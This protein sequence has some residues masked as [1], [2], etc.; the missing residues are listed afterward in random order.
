MK[1]WMHKLFEDKS[2]EG[3]RFRAGV[4]LI[5]ISFPVSYASPLIA[6]LVGARHD[7]WFGLAAGASTYAFSWVLFGV[8]AW[9]AERKGL[10]LVK[11]LLARI[12]C[13]FR[14]N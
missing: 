1:K 8:G 4:W 12:I 7:R 14:K 11:D 6:S 9:I 3:Y 10:I 5:L 13:C 2:P